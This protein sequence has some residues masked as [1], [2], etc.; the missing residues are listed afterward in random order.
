MSLM[1]K[2]LLLER[3]VIILKCCVVDDLISNLQ[4]KATTSFGLLKH[5]T[6]VDFRC[7]TAEQKLTIPEGVLKK[8]VKS[9]AQKQKE[10]EE[11]IRKKQEQLEK[12][13]V[14]CA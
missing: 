5:F 3:L 4:I 2:A 7:S 1:C 14:S 8:E 10:L 12:L 13:N 9:Q 6:I 11:D